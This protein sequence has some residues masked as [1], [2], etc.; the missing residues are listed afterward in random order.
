M[1][2][3]RGH[4]VRDVRDLRDYRRGVVEME[5]GAEGESGA[6]Q[7]Q[8]GLQTLAEGR[9][10]EDGDMSLGEGVEEGRAEPEEE[11]QVGDEREGQQVQGQG[12]PPH[13][14]AY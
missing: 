2:E 8:G 5:M 6:S 4:G 10:E 9:E 13:P 7:R 12:H 3:E 11:G 1:N 14:A